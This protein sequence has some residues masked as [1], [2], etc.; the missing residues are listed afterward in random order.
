MI[1]AV[2]CDLGD[3][4]INFHRIDVIKAFVQGARET[5]V[6]VGEE[7]GIKLP[8]F[9]KYRRR[10]ELSIRWAY[11]KSLIT[12]REFNSMDVLKRCN[13][14]LGIQVPQEN[15]EELA[16]RWYRPLAL[17]AKADPNT[18]PMLEDIVKRG[19]KLAIV[20]NTFVP[21]GVLDRHLE[22]ETAFGFFSASGLFL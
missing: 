1:K 11:L 20:S 21:P 6:Y 19:L 3:T 10:Q 17:K 8:P 5:Y 2:L 13:I 22:Q 16:W 14:R 9:K 18:I 7:L 12:G 4:L 15:M